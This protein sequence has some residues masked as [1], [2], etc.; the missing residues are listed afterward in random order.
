MEHDFWPRLDTTE[1]LAVVFHQHQLY[2]RE[3]YINHLRRVARR[4]VPHG[5]WAY[6][7]GLLHDIVEDT[8][9]TIEKLRRMG[10][11]EIVTSAVDAVT[12]R[13]GEDYFDRIRIAAAHPLG[14]VVKLADNADNREGLS[15]LATYQ[16]D[17]ARRLSLKY[18]KALTI[19]EP[20]YDSHRQGQDLD[21]D[22]S[23]IFGPAMPA[24]HPHLNRGEDPQ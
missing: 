7:A 18:N 6:H 20:A 2:G 10:Y 23:M 1:E 14:R 24:D 17:R 16:P 11:P 5:E 8:P 9:M 15:H 22:G 3:P 4:L 13:R 21:H 19:L 12:L